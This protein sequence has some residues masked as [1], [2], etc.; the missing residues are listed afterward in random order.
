MFTPRFW[1]SLPLSLPTF[2]NDIDVYQKNDV[3][4]N[5]CV[6]V[7]FLIWIMNA[8]DQ[9]EKKKSFLKAADTLIMGA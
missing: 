9:N 7:T 5:G 1:N 4:K 3:H 8:E 2:H 6:E